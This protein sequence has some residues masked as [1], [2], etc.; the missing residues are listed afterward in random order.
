[1]AM[2]RT[3]TRPPRLLHTGGAQP[4]TWSWGRIIY[5]SA[6]GKVGATGSIVVVGPRPNT[7][8]HATPE[9]LMAS[10]YRQILLNGLDHPTVEYSR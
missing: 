4:G 9:S 10:V 2:E 8:R 3:H 5:Q 7:R 6:M 1:M